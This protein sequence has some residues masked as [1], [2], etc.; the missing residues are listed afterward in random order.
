[1][2][3]TH[4]TNPVLEK[5]VPIEARQCWLARTGRAFRHYRNRTAVCRKELSMMDAFM[6]A[7]GFG[8]FALSVGYVVACDRL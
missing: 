3:R 6:L 8:F 2:A 5:P 4:R 7:I 1:V